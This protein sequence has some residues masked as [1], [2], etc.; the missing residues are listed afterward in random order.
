MISVILSVGGVANPPFFQVL[1]KHRN[2]SP[3]GMLRISVVQDEALRPLHFCVCVMDGGGAGV[4]AAGPGGG[5]GGIGG[6]GMMM[7]AGAGGVVGAG[8]GG[9]VRTRANASGP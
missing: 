2:G 1:G 6:V 3:G 9:V 4:A 5:V 8:N 7:A